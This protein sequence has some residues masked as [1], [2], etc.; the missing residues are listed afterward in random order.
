MDSDG[1]KTDPGDCKYYLTT[2]EKVMTP[3]AFNTI[4]SVMQGKF[5]G[6]TLYKGTLKNGGVNIAPYHQFASAVPAKLKTEVANL[7]KQII[8]GKLNINKWK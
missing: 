7:K 4:K 3:G 1:C 2:V 5:K 8:S 6:G